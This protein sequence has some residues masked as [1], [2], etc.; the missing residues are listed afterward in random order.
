MPTPTAT[1]PSEQALQPLGRVLLV[2][3]PEEFLNERVVSAARD[4]VRRADPEAE[5]SDTDGQHLTPGTLGEL[6]APSL[7]STTRCIVVRGLQDV[8][9]SL[10]DGLVSY[11]GAPEPDIALVLVHEGGQKGA[12]LLTRLRKLSA[13]EEHRSEK[14][15]G[16]A[17]LDFVG[18]EVRSHGSRIDR[19]AADYLLRAVGSDLRGLA[20]AVQQLC[21]DFP[22]ELLTTELVRRYY[23]GRADVKGFDIADLAMAGRAAEALAELRWAMDTGV[24]APAITGAFAFKARQLAR[25]KGAPRGQR[26]ADLAREIGAAPFMVRKLRDQL[27]GWDEE[28]LGRV[29]TAVATADSAVKGNAADP[30][31]E[32]ERLVLTIV[33]SRG[34]AQ[35]GS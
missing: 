33:R 10:F 34:S 30:A 32:L 9:D 35:P 7:F 14:P 21:D 13:V 2:T 22:Q 8:D 1:S 5:V 26:D 11:A 12:G 6:S 20:A 28:G 4:A 3:G 17:Y 23:A 24:E 18:I 25:L 16:N 31:Y 29:V 19:D 27:R 15:K